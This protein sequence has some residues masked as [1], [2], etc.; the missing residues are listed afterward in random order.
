LIK[1]ALSRKYGEEVHLREL[2]DSMELAAFE[3]AR[4]RS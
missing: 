1:S 4:R 2:D 3:Q